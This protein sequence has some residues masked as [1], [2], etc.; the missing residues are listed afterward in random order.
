MRNRGFTLVELLASIVILSVIILIASVGYQNIQNRINEQEYENKV[1]YIESQAALYASES[2]YLTTNVQE[3]VKN[4]YVQPDNEA[5]D[6]INPKNKE[7]LNNHIVTITKEGEN[8]YGHFL[9]E[10]ESDPNKLDKTNINLEIVATKLSGGVVNNNDWSGEDVVLTPKIK[11]SKS[12][13]N[14]VKVTWYSNVDS[15][16][17]PVSGNYAEV[18]G[19]TVSA[20]Q[21]L[22]TEYRV[23]VEFNDATKYEAKRAIKIDKQQPVIYQ[24]DITVE[25]AGI[26]TNSNKNVV[27]L[28]SD[29]NGSGLAGYYIGNNPICE[30]NSYKATSKEK[31]EQTFDNGTYYVCVKDKVGNTSNTVS[32]SVSKID[33]IQPTC[34]I[35]ASGKKGTDDW[36]TSNV[37]FSLTP[38]DEGGSGVRSKKISSEKLTTDTKSYVVTGVVI[39]Q[40]GNEGTC[41]TTVKRDAT[42]PTCDYSGESTSWTKND[43][44]ITVKGID[45]MSGSSS[46]TTFPYKTSKKTDSISYTIQDNAG[47]TR[48]CSK[49]I[50]VYVDKDAP[51]CSYSGES[52][53]WTKNDRTITL[54]GTD[55]MSGSSSQTT[56]S[57]KT[58]TKTDA[59][60]YTVR[61]NV[62]NTR[63][64]S[65]QINV[66]V[67]KTA[68]TYNYSVS[69]NARG[70]GYESGATVSVSCSDSD[71]GVASGDKSSTFT[72]A[73]TNTMSGT[74]TDKV[75]NTAPYSQNYTIYVKSQSSKCN[76][77]DCL[78]GSNTC[79][80]GYVTT[81]KY[82]QC[83]E[84]GPGKCKSSKTE[85]SYSSCTGEWS[86]AT[87]GSVRE[88]DG[89]FIKRNDG[90]YTCCKTKTAKSVC[91]SYYYAWC[92]SCP[93]STWSNCATGSNTCQGGYETCWHT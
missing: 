48:V 44:T 60:S 54:K 59:P 1:T 36:Y 80:G 43:R 90:K 85:Y 16:E 82:G 77:N 15:K 71:S 3:L 28:A 56:F 35:F 76:W 41:T 8:Y 40:A 79:Q 69:G 17:I 72:S 6:V 75:G 62:G 74:C 12:A 83:A 45:T 13:N 65:Q 84:C 88:C 23:E 27:I 63:T 81:Y 49:T 50:N 20:A 57:Y 11:G 51:T 9:S 2:G 29:Q 91:T 67:D 37:S 39:D 21:I 18:S 55:S 24:E 73:G 92:N 53:S 25:K 46:Q 19:Y 47:N 61:D 38:Q 22:D 33:K 64:C 93:T 26:Y 31:V 34:E 14:V 10:E 52:T 86:Y 4:G 66:Y 5:G 68:P 70:S 78:T 42:A 89:H 30:N 58:T 32:F 7:K 87:E